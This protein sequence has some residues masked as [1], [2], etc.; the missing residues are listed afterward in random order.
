MR[1][2]LRIGIVLCFL[3]ASLRADTFTV[4]NI[5]DSGAGSLRQAIIDANTHVGMDTIAF[6]IAGAGI[7]AIAPATHL[8]IVSDAVLI[9]GYTQPGATQ[10]AAAVGTNAVILIEID[11]GATLDVGISVT[12]PGANGSVVQGLAIGGFI[13]GILVTGGAENCVVR[14]NFLGTDATGLIAR[15]N[16]SGVEIGS[17][18]EL[19]GGTSPAD[20]NLV[21]GNTA[22]TFSGALV[23]NGVATN[24][25]AQGNLVG[26]D[27]TGL[28]ALPNA[29]GMAVYGIGN[30]I[31]GTAAGAAN[32]ISGNGLYGIWIQ[33]D[34]VVQ[35]NLVGIAADG[36]SPLGNATEG[37]NIHESNDS[38]IGGIGPGEGN[39]VAYNGTFGVD[40]G[41]IRNAV[42]GN[43]I[44]DNGLL[45]INLYTGVNLPKAN[46]AGDVDGG[47]NNLQ[48]FP[49]LQAV[50]T[51]ATTHVVGK[52]DST[53]STT[54]DVD[55]YANPACSNFPREFVEGRTWLGTAPV[56]TD[57]T[58]HAAID[59]TLPVETEA[60]AR[61]T[62]TATDPSGNTSEFSQRIVFVMTSFVSGPATGGTPISL[63]GTDFADPAGM[64]IGA[65]SVPVT[66]V[67]DHTLQATSP[68][69][70]PGTV[71][72]LVVT[73][74]DGTTGTLIKAWVADFLDVPGNQQFYT[75][76][77][78]LVSNGITA[79]VG[80]GLY[81]V[82]Q[83]TLRQQMA[84]FLMKAR[85]GLCYVAATLYHRRSSPTSPAPRASRPGST[86]SWPRASR[87]AAAPAPTA[88]PTPSSDSRWP[89]CSSRPSRASATRPPPAS[90]RASATS[91]AT[92]RSPR[93][94]TTS[95]PAPSPAAAGAGTTARPTPRRAA[96]WPSSSRRRS[97]SNDRQRSLPPGVG[98]RWSGWWPARASITTSFLRPGWL[99]SA[100]PA[101]FR[102][103]LRRG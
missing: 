96:R 17:N 58:G 20:R 66:F 92:A 62:A 36:I 95:W 24:S 91:R 1:L 28:H 70:D 4:T 93:G 38:T 16:N 60:G 54:F 8:P 85:H 102:L 10:N 50:T 77:T 86:S 18:N 47:S 61:L 74:P 59:V 82:D 68:A 2:T 89:S 65:V 23:L 75:F 100:T 25:T 14:G 78:T 63:I 98:L 30:T 35:G 83:P 94:S 26:T 21:S 55:F 67:D 53:P 15:P 51:G 56:T 88:P 101:F 76:V 6:N 40:V 27:A 43:S 44:H 90:P 69:L 84:V 72:D 3:A 52:L 80:G 103:P 33:G 12:G 46:D 42:R 99:S 32:V 71:N 81:G 31:G 45:G 11:G 57:A 29:G 97:T 5:D 39:E 22:G 48:N 19:V 7:H 41:G 79:G 34:P 73:T 37:I 13:Q 64:M 87:E 9:D 49:I